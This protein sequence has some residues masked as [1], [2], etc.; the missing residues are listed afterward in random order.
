MALGQVGLLARA[1]ASE[2]VAARVTAQVTG[3]VTAQ[4]PASLKATKEPSTCDEQQK[5]VGLPF[6]LWI[7]GAEA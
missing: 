5:M 1:H 6:S 7:Q 3:Q 4:V 2:Q